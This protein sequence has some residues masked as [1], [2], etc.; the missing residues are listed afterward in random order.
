MCNI[1]INIYNCFYDLFC[2][3]DELDDNYYDNTNNGKIHYY[4][5]LNDSDNNN[6]FIISKN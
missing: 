4:G 2:R 3:F 1:F 6:F 5:Q